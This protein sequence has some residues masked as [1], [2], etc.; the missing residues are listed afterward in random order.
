[1]GS[2]SVMVSAYDDE[3]AR[4]R[5]ASRPDRNAM[6]LGPLDEV[7]DDEEVAGIFHAFDHLQLEGQTLA[8]FLD[9]AA[10]RDAVGG[11][12]ALEPRLGALAQFRRLVDRRAAF[13]DG[14]ARQD[15]RLH[16]RP[17]GAALRDLDRRGD[18][19][20]QVGKQLGHFG[21]GLE[22]VL[23]RA[24]APIGLD[25]QPPFGDADERV[26]R[27]MVL[28][29]GEQRL[30][31]GDERDAARIGE[32]DQRRL[33]GALG[34]GAVALQLDIEPVAEQPRQ[35]LAA[36]R[37]EAPWPATIAASSGPPGPP[38]STISPSVSPSSQASLRW[39][40]S[41]GGVSRKARELSRI[42]LR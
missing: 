13:A 11:D 31:G 24:L 34:R 28:A 23:G 15:R 5:A 10:G 37:R 7:G 12:P 17:E 41:F 21:A 20:G 35:R 42:R 1:M 36:P 29:A 19:L 26:M 6:R 40:C 30:V 32:L 4:A 8:I 16:S 38:V 18:R 25:Q 27:L 39:G 2:R 33:G 22:A 3:R 14:E 9:R